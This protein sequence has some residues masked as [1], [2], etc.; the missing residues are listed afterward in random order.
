LLAAGASTRMGTD[1]LWSE[2]CGKPLISWPLRAFGASGAIDDLIVAVSEG[3]MER[4][5][6]LLQELGIHARLVVGG[7]RRQDS[8]R[9]ALEV[10][11]DSE[12]VVVHDGARPFLTTRLIDDGLSAAAV[13]GAAIAAVP[14]VDTVKQVANG[15]VRATLDR[16]ALWAVQTPQVFRTSLLIA[17]HAASSVDVTD[18]AALVEALGTSVRVYMG[19]Y[20]NVKVTTPVDLRV[21]TALMAGEP[22]GAA[23]SET[24]AS[25]DI[26]PRD[27]RGSG[28]RV[29]NDTWGS[30]GRAPS[31]K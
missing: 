13:T 7:A 14:V 3:T 5:E 19:S 27:T 1:K 12:W 21:A 16:E 29:P 4:M 28:G 18:D 10:T 31:A 22:R 26:A 24:R 30:G 11:A 8:V 23:A 25:R 6:R 15:E 2:L 20:D 9:S 17:A